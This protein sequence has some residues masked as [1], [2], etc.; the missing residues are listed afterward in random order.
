MG[1]TK[2][3]PWVEKYR[4]KKISDVIFQTQAVSI[5]EQIVET[6]NMP[7]MIFHGPPGTGKTSAALAMARQ[8]Y[9]LEGMRERVLELNA[10]DERGID[11]VRDR[12]KTYTRIN[13]SNNRVNP[14]TNR[15]MPNYKMIILDEAD[16]I[17]ADAQA[18]LRRVIENYSSI[19][20]FVLICNYL[21]KIIGPI[22]SRCSVFH[23]K[24][25]ET[26]SQVDR[27]K[28]IC[29][30]EGITF[31]QKALEFL[32]T[33]SS[34]DMRK[35]IT[36]LQS[37][38][39]LYNEITENAINSVSGKPPKEVVERIFEVCKNPEGDVESVC[40]EVVYDGWDISAIFQQISEYVVE[41]D[42]IG[43]IEKSKISLE[44]A[45]RDFALLQG[46]SQYFQLA[47][48]CFHIKNTITG[49]TPS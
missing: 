49:G 23:F 15:V 3:V 46:G 13:I 32:T 22:Y 18:A 28:Y 12:I 5:M 11:V 43:D 40:K 26:N 31:D 39:C 21:H 6:F 27:L 41:C 48:A 25:I 35:S 8:I 2:D 19:S 1:A 36:I 10:S 29:N 38:A 42:F 33:V 16:M 14:E 37:T 45:N 7:H 17:T 47:S 4:P 34:G 9:G 44:L 20:R 30:Q 24:P